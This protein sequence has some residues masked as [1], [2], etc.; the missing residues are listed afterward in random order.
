MVFMVNDDDNGGRRY[1]WMVVIL[2][3]SL[4]VV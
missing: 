3:Y 1:I 4:E 2:G